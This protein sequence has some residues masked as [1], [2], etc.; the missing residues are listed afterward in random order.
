MISH[1]KEQLEYTPVHFKS[2]P[3]KQMCSVA[4][5][6]QIQFCQ[7]QLLCRNVRLADTGKQVT[8]YRDHVNKSKQ[9]KCNIYL[10]M[11]SVKI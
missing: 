4:S 2:T 11:A 3:Y 5:G 1:E 6:A 10:G 7:T 8:Q 9:N